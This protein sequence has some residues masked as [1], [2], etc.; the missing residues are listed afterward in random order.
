MSRSPAA[1]A[2]ERCGKPLS[3][4]NP[5]STCTACAR[6]SGT[7][8]HSEIPA[9]EPWLRRKDPGA[10]PH[11]DAGAVL[12]AWRTA[13]GHSQA[14]LAAMLDMTQ[15]N[16]S[17]IESG[18]S[19]SMEQR[20][21][22]VEVLG[23]TPE[24]LGL[25]S[26]PVVTKEGARDVAQSHVRWRGERRWLN[27]HRSDLAR[28]AV[29]LYPDDWRVP[30][31]PL[32]AA[33]DWSVRE[34]IPLHSLALE[35]DEEPHAVAVSGTE[36]ETLAVRPLRAGS[37]HFE[38]YTAAVKQLEPP[39]LFESR[40]SY[41]LL[42]VSLVE[43]KLR[44]G[45]ATYFDKLD[46]SEALGHEMAIACI[47]RQRGEAMNAAALR[48]HLPFRDLIG[49]PFAPER[50]AIVP[51]IATLT[52]RLRRHPQPPTFLLHW[53][54][55]AR[56]ATAGGTYDVIPAGEFQPSSVAMWDRRTDFD[57]WRNIVREY[58]E[59]LLGEPEHD[60]TR[61]TPIDY[62]GWPLYRK[63][64]QA[65]VQ[66]TASAHLL[67]LGLDALTLAAA[68]LTVVV[69]DDDVFDRTFGDAVQ[70]ND[71]GEIVSVGH[72]RSAEGIPFTRE[73]VERLL[74]TEPMASP[75]AACLALA[76]QHRSSLGL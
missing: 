34:P 75:G 10:A 59:E 11:D 25:A 1:R 24:D 7:P 4:Y 21:R 60:G 15:Q 13:A 72:N 14:V 37:S 65:L 61:S 69:I 16:L 19:P 57:L 70:Y 58:A 9:A 12:R 31:T 20:R 44:F 46:V 8:K 68:M 35:L 56:V 71:E 66:G 26:H 67:G 64:D 54:D 41:R 40:P 76:W 29:E 2:C 5:E 27:H 36:P 6:P 48:G 63:L 28:L 51:A 45:M 52:I 32:V 18:R 22:I 50:R 38:R 55:P 47:G 23:L 53:R 17:Q 39:R 33:P 43:R 73:S 30:L 42:N 74:A 62:G 49:N 3:R